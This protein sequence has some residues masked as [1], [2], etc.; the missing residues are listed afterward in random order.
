MPNDILAEYSATVT[1][2]PTQTLQTIDATKDLLTGHLR[3][4]ST[5]SIDCSRV[6][7]VD[8]S[9]VQL[10]LSARN[11]AEQRGGTLRLTAVPP[12]LRSVLQRAGLSGANDPFWNG[13]TP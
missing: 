7:E 1:L 8:L 11:T 13:A 3:T 9:I 4:G 2:E 6:D 10:L 5:L 12:A